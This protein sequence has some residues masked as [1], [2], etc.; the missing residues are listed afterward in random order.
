M[1]LHFPAAPWPVSLKAIS[2]LGT[3]ALLATGF[4]A[5][6]A[7]PTPSGFTHQFG[8]G[9]A[10]VPVAILLGAIFFM[11]SG[12]AIE[13]N[14]LFVERLFTST[15]LSLAG[16]DRAWIEPAVCKGSLRI[17]G[18]GGLFSFSGLFYSKRLGR[19]RLFATDFSHAVVLIFPD[20]TV[21]IT[22][23][24]PHAFI[25]FLRHRFPNLDT[26]PLAS[27]N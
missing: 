2:I 16:L 23:V 24:T 22:P 5:Y 11:V 18:N 19:Y 9:V 1:R 25:E 17:Y 26:T 21:V 14:D 3:V 20:R 12:Y 27:G 13:G 6:R 7:V 10:L 8:I 4:A 15:R